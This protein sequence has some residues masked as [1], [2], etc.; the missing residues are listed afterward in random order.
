MPT[1]F[2]MC[3]KWKN[4]VLDSSAQTIFVNK[5]LSKTTLDIIGEGEIMSSSQCWHSHS[6]FS[7]Q[8]RLATIT[9]VSL[10][11]TVIC[12]RRITTY[13]EFP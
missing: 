4:E 8:L 7:L 9:D 13:C 12:V 2:Q 11:L 6:G 10:V 1:L 5:W 3:E